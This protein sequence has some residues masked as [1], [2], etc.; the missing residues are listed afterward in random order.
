MQANA[1]A[2]VKGR[3]NVVIA[4]G[5]VDNEVV[6]ALRVA[7]RNRGGRILRANTN[8]VNL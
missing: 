3:A 7:R 6:D 4:G 8:C 2:Q 5:S 1:D